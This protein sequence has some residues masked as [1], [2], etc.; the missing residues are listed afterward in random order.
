MN[1]WAPACASPHA[2]LPVR[3][4]RGRQTGTQLPDL[5]R[6]KAC[7][8]LAEGMSLQQHP[9]VIFVH[10]VAI[11]SND[12]NS[13]SFFIESKPINTQVHFYL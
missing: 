3:N 5:D 6:G 4:G 1:C 11:H 9:F 13:Y 7:P 2:R 10:L 8:E 12:L